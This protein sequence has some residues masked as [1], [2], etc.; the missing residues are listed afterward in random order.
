MCQIKYDC[1]N[2]DDIGKMYQSTSYVTIVYNMFSYTYRIQFLCNK[3][4]GKS[5]STKNRNRWIENKNG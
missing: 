4:R 1:L 3:T 2:T 5:C